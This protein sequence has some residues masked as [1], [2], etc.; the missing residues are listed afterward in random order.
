MGR[1]GNK[2][3]F[4]CNLCIPKKKVSSVH[5]SIQNG[6]KVNLPSAYPHEL[7]EFEDLL[8]VKSDQRSKGK[9]IKEWLMRVSNCF[10]LHSLVCKEKVF[11]M[12][13]H[14]IKIA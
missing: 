13:C 9:T 12:K 4:H 7:Q 8:S 11:K 10:Y 2:L 6:L 3:K 5:S 14:Q 1:E